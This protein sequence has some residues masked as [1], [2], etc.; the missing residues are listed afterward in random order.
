VKRGMTLDEVKAK[1]PTL[2]F[3][4]RYDTPNSFWGA[5]QFIE[6]IY[7]QMLAANPPAKTAKPAAPA[8][9]VK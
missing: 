2:D 3:D 5:S 7:R 1:K 9:R 8:R 4:L 6:V